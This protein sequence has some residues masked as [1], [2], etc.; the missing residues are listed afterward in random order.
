MSIALNANVDGSG[1]VQTGNIDGIQISA[2]Q[3]VTVPNNLAVTGNQTV[4]GNQTVTG[5]VGVGTST[6]TNAS[7]VF[8]NGTISE[9]VGTTQYLVASQYDVG[10][11]PNQLPLNQYLGALA[12]LSRPYRKVQRQLATSLQTVFTITGNYAP[13]YIDVYQ[14]GVKLY[15]SDY[16]ETNVSTITLTTGAALNDEI[17]FVIWWV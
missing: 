3:N 17:E 7:K 4:A 2:T 5:T 10:T 8:A 1:S 16:T 14:N 9:T 12:F 15:S 11:A 13:G 6:N